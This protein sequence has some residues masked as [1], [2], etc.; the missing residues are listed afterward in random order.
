[1]KRLR[2]RRRGFSSGRI[3]WLQC[4]LSLK[5]LVMNSERCKRRGTPGRVHFKT[6]TYH[7]FTGCKYPFVEFGFSAN[8]SGGG[9][10]GYLSSP[11]FGQGMR[12]DRNR[13]NTSHQRTALLHL[14]HG[15]FFSP[16]FF[17]FS[18]PVSWPSKRRHIHEKGNG[19]FQR[20]TKRGA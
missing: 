19:W 10:R 9:G 18:F 11:L 13:E 6:H 1:M 16:C 3:T 17:F 5:K 4:C 12:V 15:L 7:C 20:S 2:R 8:A 14:V